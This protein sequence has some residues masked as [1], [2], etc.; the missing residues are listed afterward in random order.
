MMMQRAPR[1]RLRT[2]LAHA[3]RAEREHEPL[4]RDSTTLARW[5]REDAER[6]ADFTANDAVLPLR[7]AEFGHSDPHADGPRV[8]H[9]LTAG[10]VSL[11]CKA[12]NA[13]LDAAFEAVLAVLAR[14]SAALGGGLD[15]TAVATLDCGTHHYAR[16]LECV[17]CGDLVAV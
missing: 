14:P 6:L 7:A 5:L 2:P 12:R 3:R 9:L 11:L 15:L 16:A 10:G 13:R 4:A 17:D 8:A 1:Q